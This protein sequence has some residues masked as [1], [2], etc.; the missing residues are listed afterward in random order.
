MIDAHRTVAVDPSDLDER[1]P[2]VLEKGHNLV[3][4]CDIPLPTSVM[5][6]LNSLRAQIAQ[7]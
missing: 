7:H 2:R 4:N 5:P 6:D 1:E 3:D